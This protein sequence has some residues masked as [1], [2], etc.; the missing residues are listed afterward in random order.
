MVERALARVVSKDFGSAAGLGMLVDAMI[1][2]A[3]PVGR[4][5]Y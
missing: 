4:A 1:V 2:W 3:G 5:G